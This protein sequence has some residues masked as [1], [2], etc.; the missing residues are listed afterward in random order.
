MKKNYEE[1]QASV[2]KEVSLLSCNVSQQIK[3][4]C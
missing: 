3:S 1:G 2:N 4:Q